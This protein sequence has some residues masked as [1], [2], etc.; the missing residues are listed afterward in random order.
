MWSIT[1][2]IG[3]TFTGISEIRNWFVK[4]EKRPCQVVNISPTFPCFHLNSYQ[5]IR[6][7]E[8]AEAREYLYSFSLLRAQNEY[9]IRLYINWIKVVGGKLKLNCDTRE[10]MILWIE[11]IYLSFP[12][13]FEFPVFHQIL[14]ELWQCPSDPFIF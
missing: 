7:A 13:K 2:I 1:K 9:P 11:I 3:T 14:C 5:A 12:I 8:W 10:I 4:F 6:A